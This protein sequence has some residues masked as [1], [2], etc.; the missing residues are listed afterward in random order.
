MNS[1]GGGDD[2]DAGGGSSSSDSEAEILKQFEVSVSRSQS[3]RTAAG[4]AGGEHQSHHTQLALS[5]RH[6]FS[7]LSDQEEGS[8]EPSDCEGLCREC[9]PVQEGI[10]IKDKPNR[11]WG[12]SLKSHIWFCISRVTVRTQ[13][14]VC[15]MLPC[16]YQ[17]G[18]SSPR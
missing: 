8:T 1:Y 4:A 16:R 17:A 7:R 2:D 6:K 13:C 5:R 14:L 9:D 3:F 11:I 18:E 12:F 10:V 15:E